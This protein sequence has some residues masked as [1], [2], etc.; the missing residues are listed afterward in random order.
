MTE[1]SG[2]GLNT[3]NVAHSVGLPSLLPQAI[4]SQ[5]SAD[6]SRPAM[7]S[8]KNVLTYGELLERAHSI[9]G[10]LI[11]SGVCRETPVAACLPRGIAMGPAIVGTWLAGGYYV[12][13]D[14]AGPPKRRD[15]MLRDSNAAVVIA[16]AETVDAVGE[17]TAAV[18]TISPDGAVTGP[19]PRIEIGKTRCSPQS[20]AY[21]IY[22]SGSTGRPK[23]VLIEHGNLAALASS[24]EAVLYGGQS[25]RIQHV[26]LN[27]VTIADSFFSDFA[28]LA[29]GRTLHVIDEATRRDPDRLA[30]FINAHGIEVLDGTPTQVQMVVLAGH[31]SALASLTILVLGGEPPSFELWQ[32]LSQLAGVAPYNLY[33]PTECTVM[34]TAAALRDYPSPMLGSPLPGCSVWVVDDAIRQ[35]PNGVIGELLVTG[36]QVG[37]GYLNPTPADAARFIDFQLPDSSRTVRAYL[38]GDQGR[39]DQA[40]H[41]EFLG[42]ADSQ[43]SISGH[44]VEI[45]EVE[46][47]L[48]RCIGVRA[49]AVAARRRQYDVTLAAFA[50]LDPGVRIE[51]I[52]AQL[53][54][55]LP[56]YMIPSVTTVD[57]I[58]MGPTGKADFASFETASGAD[59]G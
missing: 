5:A 58:P 2:T 17:N 22:T 9:A 30:H 8:G 14:P 19:C 6:S 7:V 27:N 50:V 57:E 49:A 29:Y 55:A 26:A 52:Q 18:M 56:H 10:R 13:L 42:R 53:A 33:G 34:V 45:G 3:A 47:T 36:D 43:V 1:S 12:P 16:T 31:A 20:L 35:V 46:T 59:L 32:Q 40:Q 51:N 48:R 44:R 38:T 39:R 4:A 21:V 15:H 25:R 24:Q 37:R 28:H 54:V 23:G 41:L 11:T